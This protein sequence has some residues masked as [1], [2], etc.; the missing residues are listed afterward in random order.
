MYVQDASY[1]RLSTLQLGYNLP[2]DLIKGLDKLRIYATGNNLFILKS[3]DYVGFDPDVSSGN[4]G[5]LER[6]FDAIAYPQNRSLLLG[7]NVSF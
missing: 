3:N 2:A 1:L 7:L 4:A 6:G 5:Q